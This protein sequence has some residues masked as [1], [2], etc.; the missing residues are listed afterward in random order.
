MNRVG[1]YDSGVVT[2]TSYDQIMEDTWFSRDLPVLDAAVRHVDE[3]TG[4]IADPDLLAEEAGIPR[5][6]VR[7]SLQALSGVYLRTEG[8]M[9]GDH[10]VMDVTPEAR[11]AV[12][13]WPTPE[14]V[15]N[16]LLAVLEQAAD[17]TGDEEQRTRL[18]RAADSLKGLGRDVLPEV[19][20]SVITKGAMG[21]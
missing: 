4:R 16:R 14:N 21:L 7:R 1:L 11:R 8:T 3:D 6:D 12:G 17:Q 15:A 13:Q 19:I 9:Q 20:A 18:R 2:R 10:L 5:D